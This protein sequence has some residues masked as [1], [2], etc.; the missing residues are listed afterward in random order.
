MKNLKRDERALEKLK[1]PALRDRVLEG[2]DEPVSAILEVDLPPQQVEVWSRDDRL[3]SRSP[4]GRKVIA[5]T[6]DRQRAN[7]DRIAR[8]G[9]Y[10]EKVIGTS[11]RWLGAARAFTFH[12]TPGQLREIAAFELTRAVRPNRRLA[13]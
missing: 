1:D 5:E 9:K 3:R 11:A 4:L 6:A 12:A 13:P 2:G 7:A 8:T 10:I